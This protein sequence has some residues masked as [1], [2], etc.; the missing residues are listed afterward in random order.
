VPAT[1]S[2]DAQSS[3]LITERVNERG[4]SEK[5]VSREEQPI[6]KPT[7]VVLSQVAPQSAVGSGVVG[8]EPKKVRTIAIRPDQP[9]DA[10]AAASLAAPAA[11][12]APQAPTAPAKPAAAPARPAE[13][14]PADA[15]S[16]SV[17]AP[18]A[19][20]AS[21][22]QAMLLRHALKRGRPRPR[23][24]PPP[25]HRKPR[26]RLPRP[27]TVAAAAL[28]R[29]P[30]SEAR[31][32][33]RLRSVGYKPSSRPSLV[34]A[35][36]WSTE[37]TWA[38]KEPT[39]ERWLAPSRTRRKPPNCAQASRPPAASASSREIKRRKL[40]P[41][42]GHGLIRADGGARVYYWAGGLEHFRR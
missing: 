10:Q 40:D 30:R 5:L 17:P 34:V 23:R 21:V 14:M 20:S 9:V 27:A 19:R 26:L 11:T 33:P 24:R 41:R 7:T 37:P 38:P 12:R 25:L 6:D 29:F 36:C 22:R 18:A 32:R 3:K 8:S 2:K 15:D 1:N 13:N 31:L 42:G 39:I 4:Q 16:E 28:S 35:K